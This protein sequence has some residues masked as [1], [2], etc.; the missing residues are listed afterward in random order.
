MAAVLPENALLAKALLFFLTLIYVYNSFIKNP[1]TCLQEVK[2]WPR[3]GVIRH[4][5]PTN[6][7]ENI[8]AAEPAVVGAA[9][10]TDRSTPTCNLDCGS[11]GICALEATAASSRC[12]CPF[13]KTGTGCQEDIRAHVPRFAKRSWLAFPALHGAYKHVQLRIEFR[14]ESFDGIILLSGRSN[15]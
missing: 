7:L 5:Q 8:S 9:M 10:T 14:P 12:L 2:N 15:G 13:G 1:C 11:D 4:D 3:E 6:R